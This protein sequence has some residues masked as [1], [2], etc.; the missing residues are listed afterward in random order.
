MSFEGESM[1]M[2]IT[3]SKRSVEDCMFWLLDQLRERDFDRSVVSMSVISVLCAE[4]PE[5]EVQISG[6]VASRG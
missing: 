2:T 1:S 4:E 5:Y 3:A 6:R